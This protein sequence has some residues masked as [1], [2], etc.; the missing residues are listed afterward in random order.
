ME[1]LITMGKKA[2]IASRR[3]LEAKVGPTA[4]KKIVAEIAPSY[5]KRAGGYTRITKVARRASDG[6]PQAVIE[7]VK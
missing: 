2:T 7:L 3:N 4:A 1:K 5:E 6:S